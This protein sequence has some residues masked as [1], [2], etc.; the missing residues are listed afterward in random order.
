MNKIILYLIIAG[1]TLAPAAIHFMHGIAS[2]WVSVLFILPIS[3]LYLTQ[4]MMVSLVSVSLITIQ[5]IYFFFAITP[6]ETSQFNYHI[7]FYNQTLITSILTVA[8][9]LRIAYL[10]SKKIDEANEKLVISRQM[11]SISLLANGL[12]H[13][14]NNPLAIIAVKNA[15]ISRSI[16]EKKFDEEVI[17]QIPG[18]NNAI[19]R[20]TNIIEKLEIVGALEL[21]HEKSEFDLKEFMLNLLEERKDVAGLLQGRNDLEKNPSLMIR[22]PKDLLHQ[23]FS[24]LLNNAKFAALNSDDHPWIHISVMRKENMAVITITNSGKALSREVQSKLFEAFFTTKEI[25]TGLGLGL[26]ITRAILEM[27]QGTVQYNSRSENPQFEVRLP[28]LLPVE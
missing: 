7:S 18:I 9:S 4:S 5:V 23:A 17:K 22:V 15:L 3:V 1:F 10:F 28:L 2:G 21:K 11:K 19:E 25:G 16:P 13:E 6:I 27:N 12:A 20:I 8:G 26:S 14:V 24:E